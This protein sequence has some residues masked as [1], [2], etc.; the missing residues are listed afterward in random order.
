MSIKSLF[1]EIGSEKYS[2]TRGMAKEFAI[3][4]PITL[5]AAAAAALLM[6]EVA[7]TAPF[8]GVVYSAATGAVL[9]ARALKAA[10]ERDSS[11]AAKAKETAS[12]VP[13]QNALTP[14]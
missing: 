7:P 12:G 8:I 14:S 1:N 10:F 4:Y 9:T 3:A 11:V 13:V 6:P 5:I 2:G